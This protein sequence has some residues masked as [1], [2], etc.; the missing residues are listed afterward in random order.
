[1]SRGTSLTCE[2]SPFPYLPH[3]RDHI[4]T[5]VVVSILNFNRTL[6]I[7]MRSHGAAPCP[8]HRMLLCLNISFMDIY[9]LT[10]CSVRCLGHNHPLVHPH[11]VMPTPYIFY[12]VLKLTFR[13]SSRR[14]AGQ[15]S[16]EPTARRQQMF[17]LHHQLAPTTEAATAAP[18]T[19]VTT[20]APPTRSQLLRR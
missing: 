11:H 2:V 1:M 6:C 7:F 10:P 15:G 18:T 4:C 14:A 8:Q 3:E 20:A 17:Q 16:E 5:L 13:G 12:L 9:T 19:E